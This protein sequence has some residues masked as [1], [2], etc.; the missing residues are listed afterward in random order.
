MKIIPHN[1][2]AS[3]NVISPLTRVPIIDSL[4]L[5]GEQLSPEVTELFWHVLTTTYILYTVHPLNK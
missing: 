1:N 2:M 4:K 5:P 3:F